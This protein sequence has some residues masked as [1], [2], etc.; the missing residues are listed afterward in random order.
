MPSIEAG[1]MQA[2]NTPIDF[3]GINFYTRYVVEA[4]GADCIEDF[5]QVSQ[6]HTG[7]EH[8]HIGWEIHAPALY[9][10][11]T[12]LNQ[13]YALPPI[14]ITENGAACD[15]HLIDG[16]VN[17][18]QRCHY[19]Q[20]H[21]QMVDKA[22]VDGVDIRGYFAWSLM[23]NFEWAEGYSKRFGLVHVD[24]STQK[25]TLKKSAL[26]FKALLNSRSHIA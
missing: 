24:Y 20:Q 1:D 10:L 11:L 2:I 3:L 6:Q 21:L 12:E 14:Y 19:L 26:N 18:L 9:R 7:A 13:R 16:E 23:D 4:P 25:R 17:D 8:T 22:I 5:Q 15:D